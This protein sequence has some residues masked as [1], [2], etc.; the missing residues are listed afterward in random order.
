MSFN[1]FQIEVTTG[2]FTLPV[3]ILV[4]LLLWGVSFQGWNELISLGI[5]TIIGYVLIETNTAFNLIR[6]RT[7]MPV[8]I[9]WLIAS[10]LFFLHPFEWTNLVPLIYLLATYQ[11]FVSYESPSLSPPIFHT[12][13]LVSLGSMVFPPFLYIVPLLWGSMIPFRA[14]NGKSFLASWIGLITPYWFLF[15]YGVYFDEMHLLLRP[16]QEALHFH[17]IDYRCLT[18]NEITSWAY[19]TVLLLISGIHYWQI[20]YMD[21]TRTRIFHSFLA[22]AGIWVTVCSIL[23][24]V[25]VREWMSIQLVCTA[26]LSGHLFSLTRNRFSGIFFIVTFVLYILLMSFNL[27]MQYFNS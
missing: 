20:A 24:P 16:L 3:V 26:F 2:R 18:I 5:T 9:Y 15:G 25:Y 17:P 7:T 13:L 19:I 12:F 6:T 10:A 22:V 21:K 1:R 8:C 11:L 23:Q 27:W 4:C 14:M